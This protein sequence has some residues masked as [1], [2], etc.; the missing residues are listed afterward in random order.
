[1]EKTSVKCDSCGAFMRE[2]R[3]L[4]FSEHHYE[5]MLTCRACGNWRVDELLTSVPYVVFWQEEN[6][7]NKYSLDRQINLKKPGDHKIKYPNG[8][9][10]IRR[11]DVCKRQERRTMATRR[12]SE[13]S[14]SHDSERRPRAPRSYRSTARRVSKSDGIEVQVA[15][16]DISSESPIQHSNEVCDASVKEEPSSE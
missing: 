11:E 6:W 15:R 16:P 1:M 7:E 10:E 14:S 2:R 4:W 12:R 8:W 13:N 5:S 3:I 9:E